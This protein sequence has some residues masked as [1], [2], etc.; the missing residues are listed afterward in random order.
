MATP[1]KRQK[2]HKTTKKRTWTEG[3]KYAVQKHFGRMIILKRL[4]GKS[5][6]ETCLGAE[7]EL[8]GRTCKNVKD[9][10]RNKITARGTSKQDT[11]S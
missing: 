9:F 8:R 7:P 3:E 1:T 2:S 10:V 11:A 4:P 5:E 6:I